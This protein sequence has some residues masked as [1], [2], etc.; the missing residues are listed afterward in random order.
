MSSHSIS[1]SMI[2]KNERRCK[3]GHYQK[4]ITNLLN[5]V[6][7]KIDCKKN[8][9]ERRM[10]FEIR[11]FEVCM[12]WKKTKRAQVQQVDEISI[13]KLREKI[14]R[15]SNNSLHNCN[16]CKN[17]WILWTVLENSRI[18]NQI[19]VEECL[20]FPANLKWFRVLVRCSAATEDCRLIHGINPE[21]RKTFL[22][23]NFLRL[24]HLEIIL[25]EFNLTTCQETDEQSL[26]QKGRR[27][28]TQVKTDKIMAQLQ[29]R[30][31][32]QGCRIQVLQYRRIYRRTTWSD[33]KDSKYR[34]C[35]STNSLIHNRS[36]CLK[37]EK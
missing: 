35:N 1:A 25:K 14:T 5:L 8:C 22:E 23:I 3:I 36:W 30:H 28:V 12:S 26:E 2:Y 7:N 20:T 24:I 16:N 21:Y 4:Y 13:Q 32:R 33:S 6:E 31:L 34:N 37:F 17:R 15:L 27:L 9:Y 10:L 19:T 18:L 29:C 11:R